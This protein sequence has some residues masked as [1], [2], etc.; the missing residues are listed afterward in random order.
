M[1]D[2]ELFNKKLVMGIFLDLQKAFDTVNIDILLQKLEH[3]GVRGHML[4]WFSSYLKDRKQMTVNLNACSKINFT[5]CGV[6][7]GT[8]LGPLLFLV[9]I[10]DIGLATDNNKIRLFA[11]DS[12]IFITAN[13]ADSLFKSANEIVDKLYNW[14]IVNKLSI[15]IDKTNYMIFKP[16]NNLNKIIDSR[17]LTLK[18]GSSI[19]SRI[20]ETKYLGIVIDDNLTWCNHISTLISKV[21]SMIG[22]MYKR[23]HLLPVSCIKNVYFSL[24][25][26]VLIYG[27]EIYG[28]ASYCHLKPL[29]TKC[30]TLL[31]VLQFS[32]K[33]TKVVDLYKKYHTLPIDSLFHYYILKLM[34]RCL[35]DNS[36]LPKVINNLFTI[37]TSIHDHNTRSHSDFHLSNSIDKNSLAFLGPKL[38]SKLPQVIK[39]VSSQSIF[40]NLVKNHLTC[41]IG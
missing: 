24:I 27:I 13:D 37:N 14:L 9:Y 34:H 23:R 2:N 30:N 7:Q 10:N 25:H 15:N 29:I 3:Y 5:T 36:G 17:H 39:E 4:R 16:N 33:S 38:W 22:I 20:S 1:L 18:I 31:R 32:N 35:H 28:N 6:P 19:I 8:V 12:N 41:L 26:S 21:S 11:D 40:L